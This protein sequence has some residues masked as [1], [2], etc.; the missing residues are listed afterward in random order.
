MPYGKQYIVCRHNH[1]QSATLSWV[2]WGQT[3]HTLAV[4]MVATRVAQRRMVTKAKRAQMGK[5]QNSFPT[6]FPQD[7]AGGV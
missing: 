6:T 4:S 7:S 5:G 1:R 3:T 2:P